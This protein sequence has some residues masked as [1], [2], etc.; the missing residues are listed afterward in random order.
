ME[1]IINQITNLQFNSFIVVVILFFIAMFICFNGYT[2]YRFV[3][4]L[5]GFWVG[6][7]NVHK[8]IEFFNLKASDKQMLFLQILFGVAFMLLCWFIR[9]VGIFIVVFDF[10]YVYLSSVIVEFIAKRFQ[11][12]D[13]IYPYFSILSALAIA[14]TVALISIKFEYSIV[15]IVMAWIGGF[16]AVN[17]LNQILTT[18]PINLNFVSKIP[19]WGWYFLQA[20]LSLLGMLKQGVG[21]D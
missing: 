4:A 11:I 13:R 1:K 7:S 3:L 15:V 18:G 16:A 9:K 14:L 12:S 17:Y 21:E 6:F 5:L 8:L 19:F 2:V 10:I 20:F